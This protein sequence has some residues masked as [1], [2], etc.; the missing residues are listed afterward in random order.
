M[1][2]NGLASLIIHQRLL[3]NCTLDLQVA[4]RQASFLGLVQKISDDYSNTPKDYVTSTATTEHMKELQKDENLSRHIAASF[5]NGR[6]LHTTNKKNF[7][8]GLLHQRNV[9]PAKEF[10]CVSCEK[11]R[12][13]FKTAQI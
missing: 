1:F 7:C 11:K 4:Y 12:I 13:L 2:I 8:G 9:F 3:E 10:T 5:S 6:L